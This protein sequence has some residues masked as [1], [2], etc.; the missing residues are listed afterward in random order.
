MTKPCNYQRRKVQGKGTEVPRLEREGVF[1]ME[2]SKSPLCLEHNG[3]GRGVFEWCEWPDPAR[4][5]RFT[6]GFGFN[7]RLEILD[8]GV[9]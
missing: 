9:T 2:G 5:L 8:Q 3:R 1:W 7:G 4:V 6:T